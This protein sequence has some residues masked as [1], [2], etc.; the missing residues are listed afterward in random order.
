[1]SAEHQSMRIKKTIWHVKEGT[2]EFILESTEPPPRPEW[3][4]ED[5]WYGGGGDTLTFSAPARKAS[6][7]PSSGIGVT[8]YDADGKPQYTRYTWNGTGW[9]NPVRVD[10]MGNPL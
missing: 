6:T 1:M 3:I 4:R 2:I 5:Q 10:Q 9:I 7:A 8:G